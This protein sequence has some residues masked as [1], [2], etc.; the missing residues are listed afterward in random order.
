MKTVAGGCRRN[1]GGWMIHAIPQMQFTA[2]R[3]R[4]RLSPVGGCCILVVGPPYADVRISLPK[5]R[6]EL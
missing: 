5:M 1:L 3:D 2:I 6:Q 4:P